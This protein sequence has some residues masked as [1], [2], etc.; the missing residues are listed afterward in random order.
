MQL[1]QLGI[2][3]CDFRAV[4]ILKIY[5]NNAMFYRLL[6]YIWLIAD[7]LFTS[8][9]WGSL[10]V[11]GWWFL[12]CVG[13]VEGGNR[14]FLQS[15]KSDCVCNFTIYKPDIFPRTASLMFWCWDYAITP[16]LLVSV[17]LQYGSNRLSW[18]WI[19]R[20]L[21]A[22]QEKCIWIW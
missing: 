15:W 5:E 17:L 7:R 19:L 16:A 3:Y 9:W 21:S 11:I 1:A 2:L 13:L 4:I 12:I 8:F 6:M 18:W 14:L 22:E 10:H 20:Q